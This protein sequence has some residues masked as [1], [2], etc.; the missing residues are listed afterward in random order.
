MMKF[1]V[2]LAAAACVASAQNMRCG[3]GTVPDNV[4]GWCVPEPVVA[5]V[6]REA[7]VAPTISTKQ[8][9]LVF[10]TDEVGKVGL[11][12]GDK[13][14]Y[15]E[16]AD[17]VGQAVVAAINLGFNINKE[18]EEVKAV[19]KLKLDLTVAIN[20]VS[21]DGAEARAKL[22]SAV[23]ASVKAVDA[24]LAKSKQTI[25]TTIAAGQKKSDESIRKALEEVTAASK[26]STEELN[27]F[28]KSTESTVAGLAKA[29]P[30]ASCA[31]SKKDGD[32]T[33][34]DC[35]GSCGKTCSKGKKCAFT[36]DCVNSVCLG[37]TCSVCSQKTG[38]V[39][40]SPGNLAYCESGYLKPKKGYTMIHFTTCGKTGEHPPTAGDCRYSQTQA[41]GMGM[42]STI[43]GL[44][45][46]VDY[47]GG[48]QMF[49][50]PIDGT[51]KWRVNGAQGGTDSS[52]CTQYRGAFG[53]NPGNH[54]GANGGDGGSVVA[55]HTVKAGTKFYI[56]VGQQGYDCRL[57]NSNPNPSVQQKRNCIYNPSGYSGWDNGKQWWDPAARHNGF[58]ACGG[59]NGGGPAICNHDPGG[60][61]GGGASDVRMCKQGGGCEGLPGLEKRFLVGA[62]GGGGACEGNS[63]HGCGG[64]TRWG[65]HGGGNTGQNGYDGGYNGYGGSQTR[66]GRH[67]QE[68][69]KDHGSSWGTLGQ[70][71]TGGQNDAGGGGGG[72]YGGGGAHHNSGGGGGS[73]WCNSNG[74]KPGKGDSGTMKCEL[75]K[76]G[77]NRGEGNVYLE[78]KTI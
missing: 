71:G 41:E 6:R 30:A 66:G 4:K 72:Y 44:N 38:E 46:D 5:K 16:T 51:Y 11:K 64:Y 42:G 9:N 57:G 8:N 27:T 29:V 68:N 49:T 45:A 36:T 20:D 47:D 25:D 34:V 12:T 75:N 17:G 10:T 60:A 59:F 2:H 22:S 78:I 26:K 31:N 24:S 63:N 21:K 77:Y 33:D 62:G 53:Y 1:L 65:G 67:Q 3:P 37:G 15:I 50:A 69:S 43:F 13:T 7:P 74:N 56:R 52:C 23:A 55:T 19:N 58:N 73:N 18:L 39:K 28:K 14:Q 48:Y 54:R 76:Q 32:E 61:S 35:G 70:G 40:M